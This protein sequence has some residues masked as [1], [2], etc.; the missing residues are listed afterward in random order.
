MSKLMTLYIAFEAI[1]DGRLQLDERLPV[2][3]HAMSF[4][5]STMFLD[6]TDRVKVE[7]LLRGVIVLSGNDACVVL[8]E[9][10]SPDG[11]EGGFARLSSSA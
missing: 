8:A 7:D 2:S 4:G 6:T 9:A 5:G 11:T 1:R 10:L 3:A